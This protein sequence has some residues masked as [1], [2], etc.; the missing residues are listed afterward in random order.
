LT[1]AQKQ[2]IEQTLAGIKHPVLKK[3]L[4]ALLTM[5]DNYW[6]DRAHLSLHWP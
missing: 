4:M 1:K 5:E 6:D 3:Q 2:Q